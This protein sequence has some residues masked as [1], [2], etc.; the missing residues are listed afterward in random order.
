MMY[1][2][3]I[4]PIM[5]CNKATPKFSG[6]KIKSFYF[7]MVLLQAKDWLHLAPIG[8]KSALYVYKFSL[9]QIL[10]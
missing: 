5:L 1:E 3:A 6:L 9:D 7:W 4:I 10:P 2:L 8:F